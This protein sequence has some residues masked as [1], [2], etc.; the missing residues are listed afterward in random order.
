[1]QKMHLEYKKKLF[2]KCFYRD[3]PGYFNIPGIIPS[4][5]LHLTVKHLNQ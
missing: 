4:Y 1:M 3:K 5:L 2:H